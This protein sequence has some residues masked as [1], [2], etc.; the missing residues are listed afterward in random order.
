MIRF[1]HDG[2]DVLRQRGAS[3]MHLDPDFSSTQVGSGSATP[4][5][6]IGQFRARQVLGRH[7]GGQVVGTNL[8]AAAAD[9]AH[10]L[11]ELSARRDIAAHDLGV[12]G[13]EFADAAAAPDF[14]AGI[15]EAATHVA[16][17]IGR[18]RRFDAVAMRGA[19]FDGAKPDGAA[20]AQERRNVP[21]GGD[22]VRDDTEAKARCVVVARRLGGLLGGGGRGKHGGG[23]AG[24]QEIAAGAHGAFSL[25]NGTRAAYPT[26]DGKVELI[27]KESLKTKFL[28]CNQILARFSSMVILIKGVATIF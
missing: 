7:S 17:L 13:M 14:D 16:A 6:A 9:V 11:A 19:Q 12:R 15:L 28:D 18:Q 23:G 21:G 27:A 22:V 24:G 26:G 8:D 25:E 10:Q 4:R 3:A 5:S 1:L 20:N 2:A